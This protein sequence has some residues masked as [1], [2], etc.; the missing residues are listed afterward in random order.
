MQMIDCVHP[1][2]EDNVVEFVVDGDP[3]HI[4]QLVRDKD[5]LLYDYDQ[6]F[7]KEQM[8]NKWG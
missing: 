3:D 4:H 2:F 1:K 7:T 5:G 8:I 6:Y